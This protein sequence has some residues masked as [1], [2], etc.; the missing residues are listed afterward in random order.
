MHS[1]TDI[2]VETLRTLDL[3]D[4][5]SERDLALLRAAEAH[6]RNELRREVLATDDYGEQPWQA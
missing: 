1:Y 4:L 5:L 6:H 2:F 3:H